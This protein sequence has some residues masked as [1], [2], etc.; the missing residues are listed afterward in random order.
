ML[1][2]LLTFIYVNSISFRWFVAILSQK[3]TPVLAIFFSFVLSYIIYFQGSFLGILTGPSGIRAGWAIKIK[4]RLGA[5]KAP[6]FGW[7]TFGWASCFSDPLYS[8]R[9]H[10]L[11]QAICWHTCPDLDL[12]SWYCLIYLTHIALCGS[13]TSRVRVSARSW[14]YPPLYPHF[15]RPSGFWL[16]VKSCLVG[17]SDKYHLFPRY[18]DMCFL[19]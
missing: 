16:Y 19:F 6:S 15:N 12:G 1:V 10:G 13:M 4:I 11:V 9:P 3:W 18:I 7:A 2:V 5:E 8:T 17:G 14:P